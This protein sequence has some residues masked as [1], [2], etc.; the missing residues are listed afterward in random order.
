METVEHGTS[1]GITFAHLAARAAE[2][3]M[4]AEDFAQ[5]GKRKAQRLMRR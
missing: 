5:I 3:K 4:L 1:T 2:G